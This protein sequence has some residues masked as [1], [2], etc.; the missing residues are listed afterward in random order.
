MLYFSTLFTTFQH[1]FHVIARQQFI[2]VKSY[3]TRN[4]IPLI[5]LVFSGH[6]DPMDFWDQS[7][8]KRI[9]QNDFTADIPRLTTPSLI[10]HVNPNIRLILIL[11]DPIER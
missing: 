9:P 4:Q 11:R 7:S 6:G 1:L 3:F 5:T 8:W 10:K 2:S